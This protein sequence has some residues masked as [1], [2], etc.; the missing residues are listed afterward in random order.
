MQ[1]NYSSN[2]NEGSP[3]HLC[4]KTVTEGLKKP[5]GISKFP[6]H[7]QLLEDTVTQNWGSKGRKMLL[8][9]WDCFSQ[10]K[11]VLAIFD[12]AKQDV[13]GSP[14]FPCIQPRLPLKL[15]YHTPV[16]LLL[17]PLLIFLTNAISTSTAWDNHC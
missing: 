9:T 5:Q 11:F 2:I 12:L 7:E 8:H 1:T 14:P 4:F 15:C 3:D 13:K 17:L 16:A 6:S 10:L